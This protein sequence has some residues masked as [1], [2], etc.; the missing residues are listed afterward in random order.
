[1]TIAVYITTNYYTRPLHRLVPKR[2]RTHYT[3]VDDRDPAV[4]QDPKL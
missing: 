1:M 2:H 3:T 4:P